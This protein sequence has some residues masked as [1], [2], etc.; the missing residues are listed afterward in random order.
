MKRD[1]GRKKWRFFS[2][3]TCIRQPCYGVPLEYCYNAWCGKK[4]ARM[5]W[6]PNCEKCLRICL[7]VS[8]EYTNVTDRQT[9][10]ARR[11]R[12]LLCIASRA[13]LLTAL[14]LLQLGL[15][16]LH[17]ITAWR[18]SSRDCTPP[19]RENLKTG[20]NPYI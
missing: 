4:L 18:Y 2:Y 14:L 10:I 20:T 9:D 16:G 1:T 12:P 8:T 19:R 11:H 17:E 15:L 5:V 7:L 6:L 3:A 13:N